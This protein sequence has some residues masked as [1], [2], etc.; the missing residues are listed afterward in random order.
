RPDGS[1]FEILADRVVVAAG[2]TETP[3]LLRRSGLGGHRHLG[4]N[5]YLHPAV[6][7]AGRFEQPVVAWEGVLQSAGIDERHDSDGIL[8][9]AT[10]T[11]PGMGTMLLPGH[12][13]ELVAELDAA[14]HLASIG[15]M[16][17]DEPSG[18]VLGRNQSV[19]TYNLS[20]NDGSKLLTAIGVMGRVLFAAGAIEVLTGINSG[21][22]ARSIDE[23]DE[24]ISGADI[25]SLHLAA[26][27]P[28]GTAGAGRDDQRYPVD[29]EGRLRGVQGVWVADASV[30]PTCPEVNPQVTIM[31]LAMAISKGI[32]DAQ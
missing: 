11:P 24:A 23:L 31:A 27:H 18:R 4:R 26:F 6:S 9:E 28:V 3:P 13:A 25:R 5:L 1:T 17:A 22:R 12:G 29:A 19:Q 2:T 8:I 15:A 32:V 7:I 20:R 14:D 16:I 21:P 10:S 30:L